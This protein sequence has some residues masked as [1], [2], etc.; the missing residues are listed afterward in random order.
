MSTFGFLH[1]RG[2]GRKSF[3]LQVTV[4]NFMNVDF[5][6]RCRKTLDD[7]D[8]IGKF[9]SYDILVTLPVMLEFMSAMN[10]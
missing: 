1:D 10:L 3:Y 8:F 9:K 4:F 5:Y 7:T 2:V 6:K